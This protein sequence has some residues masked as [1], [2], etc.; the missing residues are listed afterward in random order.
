ML[1]LFGLASDGPIGFG[2]TVALQALWR[3]MPFLAATPALAFEL[4][5]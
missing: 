2:C 1:H 3:A 5:E 4:R